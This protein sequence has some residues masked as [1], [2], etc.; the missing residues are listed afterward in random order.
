MRR[1]K[2]FCRN[3][4][5]QARCSLNSQIPVPTAEQAAFVAALTKR[6]CWALRF[7]ATAMLGGTRQGCRDARTLPAG[8][9]SQAIHRAYAKKAEIVVPSLRNPKRNLPQPTTKRQHS[10]RQPSKH[11]TIASGR[12]ERFSRFPLLGNWAVP[13]TRARDFASGLH[14]P[15]A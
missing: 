12:V 6:A 4:R 9:N 7:T 3:C 14:H 8:H 5:P 10:N 15:L 11:S 2:W 13:K 1:R